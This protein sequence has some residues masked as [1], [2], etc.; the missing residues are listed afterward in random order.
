MRTGTRKRIVHTHF[1]LTRARTHRLPTHTAPAHA[2]ARMHARTH[3]RTGCDTHAHDNCFV[4]PCQPLTTVI[5]RWTHTHSPLTHTHTKNVSRLGPRWLFEAS[6]KKVTQIYPGHISTQ[7]AGTVNWKA[8][9]TM[10]TKLRWPRRTG[11]SGD[12]AVRSIPTN[13]LKPLSIK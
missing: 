13:S 9:R 1:S 10:K 12:T 5:S 7:L 6:A 8:R 3:A 2:R 11:F 4:T